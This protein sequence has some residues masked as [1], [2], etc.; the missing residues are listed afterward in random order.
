[1]FRSD[2]QCHRNNIR[3]FQPQN[4]SKFKNTQAEIEKHVSYKK[5]SVLHRYGDLCKTCTIVGANESAISYTHAT[6]FAF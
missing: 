6:S 3:E 5:K 1:M 2:A 4:R